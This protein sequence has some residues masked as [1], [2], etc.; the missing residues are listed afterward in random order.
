MPD[1]GELFQKQLIEYGA[2]TFGRM[3][4]G[5]LFRI[6]R[7]DIPNSEECMCY[8]DRQCSPFGYHICVLQENKEGCLV[9]VYNA[10]K[11]EYILSEPSI[12]I[13]LSDFGYD[14]FDVDTALQRLK[15][16]LHE[17]SEFPHEIGIFLGFPLQDVQ[18]FITPQKKC[19]LVG[20]WKVYG[21]VDAARITFDRYNQA[22]EDAIRLIS[23]GMEIHELL[24]YGKMLE[25]A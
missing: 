13:F 8:F 1:H 25:S 2:C 4:T 21:D 22:K 17:Q 14:V 16:R 23:S 10:H 5:S 20:Y 18:A 12:Q 9:Y 11:L 3:K 24:L 19:K 15:Q 7:K 6:L